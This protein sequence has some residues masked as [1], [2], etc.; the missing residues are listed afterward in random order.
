[1]KGSAITNCE[2]IPLVASNTMRIAGI[3]GIYG[4]PNALDLFPVSL[5]ETL[6][7]DADEI[8]LIDAGSNDRLFELLA[9]FR[10]R[11]PLARTIVIGTDQDD[12]YI[13]CVIAAG[14]KGFLSA[15]ASAEEFRY[16]LVNVRE[17]SLWATR[18]VLSRLAESQLHRRPPGR[19]EKPIEFTQ[20]ERQI[21]GLLV[22]G[23]ANREISESLGI[24]AGTVKAHLARIMRK[25]GVGNRIELTVFA[26]KHRSSTVRESQPPRRRILHS[27]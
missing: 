27:I 21:I 15:N 18:R 7:E 19:L 23:K 26:V 4:D 24:E 20:R 3:Q 13:E 22:A 17:G 1:M 16:A 12:T 2:K 11:R 10:E 8:V 25:A 9:K 5:E 14:A 6:R